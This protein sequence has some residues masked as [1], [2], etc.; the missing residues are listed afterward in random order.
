[1][2]A[3]AAWADGVVCCVAFGAVV[4]EGN[5]MVRTLVY[6]YSILTLCEVIDGVFSASLAA[7]DRSDTRKD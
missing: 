6:K 1:M 4:C 3:V 2:R 7:I 5:S